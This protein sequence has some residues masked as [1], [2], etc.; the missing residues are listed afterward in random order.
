MTIVFMC[1]TR[2][3]ERAIFLIGDYAR[4]ADSFK[5]LM[6]HENIG[7]TDFFL[8]NYSDWEVYTKT[9]T[10]LIFQGTIGDIYS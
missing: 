7:G 10:Q 6:K 9:G 1:P 4:V 8:E 2:Y 3:A 5:D